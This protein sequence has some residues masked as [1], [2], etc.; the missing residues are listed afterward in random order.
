MPST[1]STIVCRSSYSQKVFA[2]QF[3]TTFLWHHFSHAY[4]KLK[5]FALCGK[6]L[7]NL[8][9]LSPTLIMWFSPVW[10]VEKFCRFDIWVNTG[11]YIIRLVMLWV[12]RIYIV[13]LRCEFSVVQITVIITWRLKYQNNG[14]IYDTYLKFGWGNDK[15]IKIIDWY[16]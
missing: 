16:I 15:V 7:T 3:R 8:Q 13:W 2:I 1:I 6:K 10:G 4:Y 11:F 5:R 9:T 12:W 14:L